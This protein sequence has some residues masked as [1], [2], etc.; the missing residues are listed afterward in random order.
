MAF[1][2]CKMSFQSLKG[3]PLLQFLKINTAGT[4][5]QHGWDGSGFAIIHSV[6]LF[7]T[8]VNILYGSDGFILSILFIFSALQ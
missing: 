3:N 2:S 7:S 1:Q 4:A 5:R 6:N 8:P